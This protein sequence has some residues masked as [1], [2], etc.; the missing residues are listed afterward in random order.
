[1]NILL[2]NPYE[3]KD[4]MLHLASELYVIEK[5]ENELKSFEEKNKKKILTLKLPKNRVLRSLIVYAAYFYLYLKL[6][7]KIHVVIVAQEPLE[8]TVIL[9]L[10]KLSGKKI[11]DRIGGSRTHLTYFTLHSRT[12]IKYKIAALLSLA[13]LKFTLLL[14]DVIA[15]N[16]KSLLSDNLYRRHSQKIS[17]IPN[18]PSQTFYHI[19]KVLKEYEEREYVIGYVGAFTLAKG[20]ASL[21]RAAKIISQKNPNIKFLLVGDWRHSQPPFLGYII[22]EMIKNERNIMLIG[23][24]AHHEVAKYLNEMKLLVL[25][26]Y[27]EGVPKVILEAMACG[28]PTLATPVGGIPEVLANGKYGYIIKGRSSEALAEEILRALFNK[29][30]ELLSREIRKYVRRIYNFAECLR[31]WLKVIKRLQTKN[32]T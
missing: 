17:I 29:R 4:I 11:I 32:E 21:I 2:I 26:S 25:P 27:T 22:K 24:V 12:P 3:L 13:S 7:N 20:V 19:F 5:S 30:N 28:T 23:S 8:P 6:A 31:L 15:L 1:M 18:C 9:L 10:M 16:T 14:V